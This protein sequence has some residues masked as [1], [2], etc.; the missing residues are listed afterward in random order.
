MTSYQPKGTMETIHG[1]QTYVARPSTAPKGIVVIIPDAFGQSFPNNKHLADT[2]ASD[3]S[4]LVYLP[5]FMEGHAAPSH[6]VTLF[7]KLLDA[8]TWYDTFMKPIYIGYAIYYMAPFIWYCRFKDSMPKVQAFFEAVRDNE[9][10][11]QNLPIASAGFCW[12]GQHVFALASGEYKSSKSGK[13][14]C[15]AHFT[16]HPSNVKVPDEAKKVKLP[17]SIA[18]ATRDKVMTLDQT[19][20]VEAVLREKGSKEGLKHSG[21]VYYEGAGHGFG[22]RADPTDKDV[23]KHAEASIK[24]AIDFFNTVFADVK[25]SS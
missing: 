20:Q 17:L 15:D 18:A 14:L 16:A 23:V 6:L 2:Y 13:V 11:Q 21:V 19:R 22:V 9:S 3:G 1:V 7:P 4:F 10:T 8:Q 12:G 5:E 25:G 24:Q